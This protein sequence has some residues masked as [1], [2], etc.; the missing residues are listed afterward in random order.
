MP[1]LRTFYLL[2]ESIEQVAITLKS[3]CSYRS[4]LLFLQMDI[5]KFG[6]HRF[7]RCPVSGAF[8]LYCLEIDGPEFLNEFRCSIGAFYLSNNF[9]SVLWRKVSMPYLSF[10][11]IACDTNKIFGIES[12]FDAHYF[13]LFTYKYV[14]INCQY[15]KKF[16]CSLFRAFY[17][18]WHEAIIIDNDFIFR[19]SVFRAF[20]LSKTSFIIL[21]TQ[22][23]FDAPISELF[24]Y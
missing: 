7:L 12:S 4:F 8:Y 16:R 11:F 23:R 21:V 2:K 20:H 19:C 24:I 14:S 22:I 9:S 18:S 1:L 6:I 15:F 3:R 5:T 13:E 17:L 10:L